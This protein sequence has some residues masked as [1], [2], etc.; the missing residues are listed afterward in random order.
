MGGWALRAPDWG[1]PVRPALHRHAPGLS[2][3]AFVFGHPGAGVL[4]HSAG[5]DVPGREAAPR[6]DRRREHRLRRN[7]GHRLGTSR[8]REPRSVSAGRS[9]CT[10]WGFRQRA[11][12]EY[13][14]GRH[15]CF[16]RL[17][18]PGRPRCRCCSCRLRSRAKE[19][20]P[21]SRIRAGSSLS[22]CSRTPTPAPCL[23]LEFR[24]ATGALFGG[25]RRAIR[26]AHPSRRH[27]CWRDPVWRNA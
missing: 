23:A 22:A 3:R 20:S 7:G 21:R 2:G 13:R 4:H 6:P 12:E 17:V 1:R 8:R 5:P 26:V 24:R 15:A 10:V 16:H 19:A 18:E 11:G 27:D 9:G 25:D 14:Q